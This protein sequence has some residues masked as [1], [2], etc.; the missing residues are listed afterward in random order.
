MKNVSLRIHQSFP[1]EIAV[2]AGL[3]MLSGVLAGRDVTHLT[4]ARRALLGSFASITSTSIQRIL[5]P[6]ATIE[7]AEIKKVAL[8]ALTLGIILLTAIYYPPC[9]RVLLGRVNVI[10]TKGNLAKLFLKML[11]SR[12]IISCIFREI[13]PLPLPKLSREEVIA[14]LKNF[15]ERTKSGCDPRYA[16]KKEVAEVIVERLIQNDPELEGIVKAP[17]TPFD[18]DNLQDV[19]VGVLFY[20]GDE[21]PHL[22]LEPFEKRVKELALFKQPKSKEQI[23]SLS[24]AELKWAFNAYMST[25]KELALELIRALNARMEEKQIVEKGISVKEI[26]EMSMTKLTYAFCNIDD[27]TKRMDEEEKML[28]RQTIAKA[29]IRK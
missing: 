26:D 21:I 1:I 14:T 12:A 23:E 3:G 5:Y 24:D 20:R 27:L 16:V 11:F 13:F 15:D 10:T 18:V 25:T 7:E 28:V 29:I 22:A 17:I 9:M 8:I 6:E 4:F 2:Q 19:E